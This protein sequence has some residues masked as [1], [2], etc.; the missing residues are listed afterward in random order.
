MIY[1]NKPRW[2]LAILGVMILMMNA[3]SAKAG[4]SLAYFSATPQDGQVLL[5]WET[6]T[7]IANDGFYIN[8]SLAENSGYSRVS[9][10]IPSQG[11][12]LSGA[13]YQF[14]DRGVTNGLVYWYLLEAVNLDQSTEFYQPPIS[15]VPQS[16]TK[17]STPTGTITI[18]VTPVRSATP[19][20][21]S[22]ATR[23][24]TPT[25]TV[26]RPSL[27]DTLTATLITSYPAPETPASTFAVEEPILL[28]EATATLVPMPV[29]SMVFPT[30]VAD[31]SND[32]GANISDNNLHLTTFNIRSS[33]IVRSIITLGVVILVWIVLG[34]VFFLTLLRLDNADRK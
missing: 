11:G 5:E 12:N 6:V 21:T 18:S 27:P 32:T 23:T 33:T 7:E 10:F 25:Q 28:S 9:P 19:T 26:M 16:Q 8:R 3:K 22:T 30:Q 31:F 15:A 20:I 4:A 24:L 2:W 13:I 1:E 14:Y 34:G 17:T 29:I